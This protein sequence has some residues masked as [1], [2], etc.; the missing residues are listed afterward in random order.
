MCC[1]VNV[2][3][4]LYKLGQSWM[5]LTSDKPN[6]QSKKDR[7]EYQKESHGMHACVVINASVNAN[8]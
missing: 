3:S 1:Y 2:N 4:F 6:M 7:R 8:Y 5:R